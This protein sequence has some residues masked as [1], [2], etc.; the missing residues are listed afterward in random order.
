[1]S[2]KDHQVHGNWTVWKYDK[3]YHYQ[4]VPSYLKIN[5]E[6]SSQMA[7]Y[8]RCSQIAQHRRHVGKPFA[9]EQI[10]FSAANA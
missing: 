5:L 3:L 8:S 1:M 4:T 2:F 6:T 10:R 7:F 9:T